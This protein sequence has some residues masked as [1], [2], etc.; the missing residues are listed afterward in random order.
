M[1]Q[2]RC[3]HLCFPLSLRPCV[4]VRQRFAAGVSRNLHPPTKLCVACARYARCGLVY[5][6]ASGARPDFRRLFVPVVNL[7]TQPVSVCVYVCLSACL[8]VCLSVCLPVCLSACLSARFPICLTGSQTMEPGLDT[9]HKVSA[10]GARRTHGRYSLFTHISTF[11]VANH[12]V[13]RAFA[14]CVRSSYRIRIVVLE[15]S[16]AAN[17]LCSRWQSSRVFFPG[18][19]TD[20][21]ADRRTERPDNVNPPVALVK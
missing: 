18:Q 2:T 10:S 8:P 1:A 6:L 19:P 13:C 4:E 17:S 9:E 15:I 20:R 14:E 11:N 3:F 7:L 21:L 5:I 16:Q 12:P